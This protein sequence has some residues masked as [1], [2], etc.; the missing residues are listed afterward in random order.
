MTLAPPKTAKTH[1]GEILDY[2]YKKVD[3]SRSR[4]V[5]IY[6]ITVIQAGTVGDLTCFQKFVLGKYEPEMLRD[7]AENGRRISRRASHAVFG[8]AMLSAMGVYRK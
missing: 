1:P 7:A 2:H 8:E 5:F 4:D 3:Y 6:V